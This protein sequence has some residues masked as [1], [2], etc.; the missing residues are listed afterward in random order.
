MSMLIPFIF[1][2]SLNL[3]YG[4]IRC[5]RLV[6]SDNYYISLGF[7]RYDPSSLPLTKRGKSEGSLL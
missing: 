7:V 3:K 2:R 5:K 1:F 4:Y 6:T